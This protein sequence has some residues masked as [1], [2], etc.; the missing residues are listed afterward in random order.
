MI[1]LEGKSLSQKIQEELVIKTKKFFPNNDKYIGII[2]LGNNES[3]KIYV[4]LKQKYGEKIGIKGYV[5][6]Q[7]KKGDKL[8]ENTKED[9]DVQLYMK[10]EYDNIGK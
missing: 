8:P 4:G 6:G 10:Q 7:Y 2:Y 1:L 3:S 5:F 9:Y